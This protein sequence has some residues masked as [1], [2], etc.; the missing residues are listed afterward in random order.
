MTGASMAALINALT[1]VSVT[2][3]AAIVL[4]EKITPITLVCLALALAGAAII[5]TGAG[6]RRAVNHT[7]RSRTDLCGALGTCVRV[8]AALD[9][10]VSRGFSH[11]LWYGY[12]LIWAYPHGT[13][14][15]VYGAG[16]Q[17]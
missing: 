13:L 15:P 10:Q 2:I 4:K 14:R 3:L 11:D 5:T 16:S 6:I 17:H 9:C 1:P 12:Q 7:R 8:Y